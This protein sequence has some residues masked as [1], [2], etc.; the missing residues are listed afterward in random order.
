M[1]RQD[2]GAVD[3]LPTATVP[4]CARATCKSALSLIRNWCSWI[5]RP[6]CT[7]YF[8]EKWKNFSGIRVGQTRT[9]GRSRQARFLLHQAFQAGLF[10]IHNRYKCVEPIVL[11]ISTTGYGKSFGQH[12][13]LSVLYLWLCTMLNWKLKLIVHFVVSLQSGFGRA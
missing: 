1:G 11:F 2:W 13:K 4:D 7:L 5:C 8:K 6:Y 10:L 3:M 9:V 12:I